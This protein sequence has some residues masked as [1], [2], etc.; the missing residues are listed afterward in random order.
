MISKPL[1]I[2]LKRKLLQHKFSAIGHICRMMTTDALQADMTPLQ[3][4]LPHK[5]RW[6]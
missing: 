2:M 5:F 3:V 6:Y 1:L 4:R